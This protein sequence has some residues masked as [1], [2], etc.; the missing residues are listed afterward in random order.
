MIEQ[1]AL[2]VTKWYFHPAANGTEFEALGNFTFLEVMKKRAPAKKGIACR[3]TCRFTN[4]D[5]PVLDYVAEH[6]YVIDLEDHIDKHELLKMIRNSF[7]EFNE[8]FDF[9]KLG[10]V[11]H[12]A[13]LTQID[14]TVIDLDAIVPLL[15]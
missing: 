15:I 7:S 9:R 14:E 6:S 12:Q 4:A 3:L 10:T 5:K 11:L 13:N 2:I 1:T 8:K